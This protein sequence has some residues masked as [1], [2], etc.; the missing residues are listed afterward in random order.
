MKKDRKTKSFFS[1]LI[2]VVIYTSIVF[3]IVFM[4]V[5]IFKGSKGLMNSDSSFIVDY[6]I[7]QIRTHS[8]F[9]P[10]WANSNDFWV[11]SLIPMITVLIKLGCSL[12][13]ARQ[14]SVFVQTI[15]IFMVL[16]NL[17]KKQFEDKKGLKIILIL[18]LSGV[19]GQF[20]FEVFGDAT[21]GSII[22][23]MLLEIWLLIRY[24][25]TFKKINIIL[26]SIFLLLISCCSLRFPIYIGAP[27]ICVALYMLYMDHKDKRAYVIIAKTIVSIGI[28]YILNKYLCHNLFIVSATSQGL[29]SSSNELSTGFFE[30]LFNYFSINGATNINVFSLT[31]ARY[32][33][34]I[35]ST[36]PLILIIFI[37]FIFAIVTL[38]IPFT[39]AKVFKKMNEIEKIFYIYVISLGFIIFFFLLIGSMSSWY[40]YITP[41]LFFMILLYPIFY[42]YKIAE[43]EKRKNIFK[44][45]IV[46]FAVSAI[47]LCAASCLDIN[48]KRFYRS[49]SQ[50]LADFLLSKGLSYGYTNNGYE[51]NIYRLVSN[52]NLQVTRIEDYSPFYWLNSRDWFTSKYHDGK[53]FYMR[54]SYEESMSFE[55]EAIEEYE[56]DDYVIFVFE[57]HQDILDY[58]K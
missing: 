18:L 37:R 10:D 20:I 26:Y 14:L 43:N 58:L 42:K 51:H 41:V 7:E 17:F 4:I 33:S 57:K 12:F 19:S 21:Y 34:F 48:T 30:I 27:V 55:K 36:S 28:G 53:T 45:S 13:A 25:K 56:Y 8:F 11:Y 54:H 35:T 39:L 3:S 50:N 1:K 32:N 16:I 22:F 9:P 6:S 2:D 31:Y 15:A 23:Y 40:R 52:G 47:S 49:Q 44:I 24:L 5:Y 38:L 46:L 29:T